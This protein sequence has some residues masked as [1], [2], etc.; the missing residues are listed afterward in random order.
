MQGKVELQ[1]LNKDGILVNILELN[2]NIKNL[3]D[4][5]G[6]NMINKLNIKNHTIKFIKKYDLLK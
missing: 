6:K 1:S 5:C 4:I 2:L 3:C